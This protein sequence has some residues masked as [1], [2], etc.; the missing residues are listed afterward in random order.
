MPISRGRRRRKWPRTHADGTER[1]EGPRTDAGG[2]PRNSSPGRSRGGRSRQINPTIKRKDDVLFSVIARWRNRHFG[3]NLFR[4]SIVLRQ[5]PY[6]GRKKT[7]I[8]ARFLLFQVPCLSRTSHLSAQLRTSL[9]GMSTDVSTHTTVRGEGRTGWRRRKRI[10]RRS[11]THACARRSEIH[12][13]GCQSFLSSH[14]GHTHHP[15][16][17]SVCLSTRLSLA[18]LAGKRARE[19]PPRDGLSEVTR[20]PLRSRNLTGRAATSECMALPRPPLRRM[21]AP[22]DKLGKIATCSRIAG[23][24]SAGRR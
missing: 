24:A 13:F 10:R 17:L 12:M 21:E 16:R 11:H 14:R 8:Y 3:A 20:S 4:A 1:A 15:R 7:Q 9:F 5:T 19:A 18:I 2:A 23:D 22:N 6:S